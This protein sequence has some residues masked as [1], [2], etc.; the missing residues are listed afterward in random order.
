MDQ[1]AQTILAVDD[2]PDALRTIEA[3][4]RRGG[5]LTIAASGPL[6]ALQNARAFQRAKFTCY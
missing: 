3:V 1:S 4:L 2:D 5:Y 6:E